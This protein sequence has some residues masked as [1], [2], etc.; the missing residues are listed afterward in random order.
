MLDS[1]PLPFAGVDNDETIKVSRSGGADLDGNQPGDLYIVIKLT[2]YIYICLVCHHLFIF[3]GYFTA[4]MP[5]PQ[6]LNCK[7]SFASL[8][9]RKDPV[10]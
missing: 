7:I 8:Q 3:S 2:I 9:V 1:P 5:S 10:F 6:P 4:W